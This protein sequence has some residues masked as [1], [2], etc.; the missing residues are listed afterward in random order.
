MLLVWRGWG[1]A[2]PVIVILIQLAVEQLADQITGSPG[3]RQMHPW[4]WLIGLTLAAVIIWFVGRKLESR[5]GRTVIDKET[6]AEY[7]IKAKH[8]LFW[9]PFKWWA[10]PLI[11]LG[12]TFTFV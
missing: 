10:I 8:D 3:F 12:L 11:A 5:P 7:E 4:V 9:I 6:Q 1:I 2:I